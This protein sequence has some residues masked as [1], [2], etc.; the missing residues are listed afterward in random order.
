[1]SCLYPINDQKTPEPSPIQDEQWFKSKVNKFFN[2]FRREKEEFKVEHVENKVFGNRLQNLD[3]DKEQSNVP[4]FVTT[5]IRLINAENSITT[6]GLYRASGNKTVI[7][8]VR[9]K[10]MISV[11]VSCFLANLSR[12]SMIHFRSIKVVVRVK[13]TPT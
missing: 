13:D 3:M 7:D 8:D 4:I 2:I 12:F 11:V 1:M 9:K 5:C 10:V 6:Q